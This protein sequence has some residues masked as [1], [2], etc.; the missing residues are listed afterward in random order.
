MYILLEVCQNPGILR[1]I[2]F[3]L[4]LMNV[5]FIIVPIGLIIM[6]LIDLSKV[7]I[8]QDEREGPKTNK[9]IL[10]RIIMAIVVFMVPSIVSFVA[11]VIDMGDY[12]TCIA[13]ANAS[14]IA[15]YQN[16]QDEEEKKAEEK[17]KKAREAKQ[18][19][20]AEES[21]S[22]GK[23]TNKEP[24][25]LTP[26]RNLYSQSQT[27]FSSCNP[28]N[29]VSMTDKNNGYSLGAW[30]KDANSSNLASISKKYANGNLIFPITGVGGQGYEHNGIDIVSKVGTPVYSPVDGTI[31]FSEWGHTV[32]KGSSETAYSVLI[33]VD[34][35]F[36]VQ[37]TWQKGGNTTKKVGEVFLT[38]MIGINKRITTSGQVKVHKGDFL[39]F[40]G[41]ANNC[42]H[43]HMTLYTS[44]E[45][46]GLM[47]SSIKKIYGISGS[48]ATKNA[49]G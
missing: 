8:S 37:G 45:D 14:A 18:N 36:S 47:S 43:L 29:F 23:K 7:V 33:K 35:P 30:P 10:N 26:L 5:I 2:Q 46:D 32:N 28:N 24:D 21:T 19:S 42:A 15:Y 20:N 16:I 48:S 34:K 38:H 1:I 25:P 39:G 4:I 9:L 49:G 17:I 41:V 31:S 22:P 11:K 40:S 44:T 27:T 12:S 6:L 3:I 13:N